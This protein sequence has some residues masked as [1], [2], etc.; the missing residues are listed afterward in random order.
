VSATGTQ[1]RLK[2]ER[3]VES[4]DRMALGNRWAIPAFS[5]APTTIAPFQNT[6]QK[7][8]KRTR[9]SRSPDFIPLGSFFDLE[10]AS[11]QTCNSLPSCNPDYPGLSTFIFQKKFPM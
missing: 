1:T 2:P 5:T 6:K 8:K 7:P 4:L 11:I 10:N 3:S 9:A